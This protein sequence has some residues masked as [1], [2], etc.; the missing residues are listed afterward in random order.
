VAVAVLTPVATVNDAAPV[1][2][3]PGE[4]RRWVILAVVLVGTFMSVLDV[5]I[6]NVAVPSIRAN[7]HASFAAVEFVIAA[8]SLVYGVLLVT[9]GRLGDVFGRKQMFLIGMAGFAAASALCGFA[10]GSTVLIAARALQGGFGALMV[11]Q[12]LAIIQATF[13]GAELATA[14]A[15]F[16]AVLGVS[17]TVGQLIGGALISANIAGASWRP[18]FLVNVPIGVVGLVAAAR[19]LPAG[20]AATRPRLDLVGVGLGSVALLLLAVPL[21]E[22]RDAGWPAWMIGCLVLSPVVFTAFSLYEQRL[23]ASGADPLLHPRLFRQ[24]AFTAGLGITVTFIIA[25]A[26]SLFMLALYLQV[27][28]GFTPL[29][30]GLTYTPTAAAFFLASLF[31]PRLVPIL[32]RTVLSVGYATAAVGYLLTMTV[33]EAAGSSVTG[34]ELA[35][36]LFVVGLGQG[37]GATPLFGTVLS[38]VD[39]ADAGMASGVLT[40]AVELG[41]MLGVAVLGLVFFALLGTPSPAEHASAY[42]A[43]FAHALPVCAGLALCALG[44]VQVLPRGRPANSLVERVPSW[45]A[46]FAYS[47][48]LFSGGRI[49]QHLFDEI[50]GEMAGRRLRR[51]REAPV[52]LPEFLVFHFEEAAADRPWLNYLMREALRD[53]PGSIPHHDKREAVIQAQVKEIADRQTLGLVPDDLAPGLFRLM[54]FALSNY[55]RLLPQITR[56]TTG[57]DPADPS[58]VGDWSNFLRQIAGRLEVEPQTTSA[59]ER[60]LR[61]EQRSSSSTARTRVELDDPKSGRFTRPTTSSTRPCREDNQKPDER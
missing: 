43:T 3:A 7:L 8:Y 44:L 27:G 5:A 51:T 30:A 59:G 45:A 47:M 55:P 10:P 17:A 46:S 37:L 22:G 48:Y 34:W 24:R 56:M 53:G 35:P 9:G 36:A 42:A 38:G 52:E 26:G 14:L 6:V 61:N 41:M 32:G 49:A 58:F 57:K 13:V 50:L 16:G 29:E 20:R 15:A 40:T 33:A 28:L 60:P 25:N 31:A 12:V 18:T 2:Q 1:R 23:A 39:V 19:V 21:V 4:R 11:P 54:V